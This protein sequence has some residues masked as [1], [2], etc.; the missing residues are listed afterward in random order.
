LPKH[1]ALWKV[2]PAPK[3]ANA[4]RQI[5]NPTVGASCRDQTGTS[6]TTLDLLDEEMSPR[7]D[8]IDIPD[9][10]RAGQLPGC[11]WRL[12]QAQSHLLRQVV[13]FT[14]VHVLAGQDTI[15]PRGLAAARAGQDVVDVAFAGAQR[16]AG[17]LAKR[18][19]TMTCGMRTAPL[20]VRTA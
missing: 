8:A 1:V 20:G 3:A 5:N 17:V 18:L 16:L 15:L 2:A 6:L 9:E 13:G 10:E 19:R 14:A 7:G 4:F 12:E 11:G